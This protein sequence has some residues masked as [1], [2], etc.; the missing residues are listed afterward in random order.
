V[1]D[2]VIGRRACGYLKILGAAFQADGEYEVRVYGLKHHA[3]IV[4]L[5]C[6]RLPLR[7]G[8]GFMR[9]RDFIKLIGGG[10]AAWPLVARAQQATKTDR[11]AV[12]HPSVPVA[13]MTESGGYPYY[14][15]LFKELRRLGY[16]EGVNLVVT[17]YSAEGREE[18]FPGLC[19]EVVRTNPDIIVTATSRL[20]LSFKATTATVPIVAIMADPVPYGI[21]PNI[22]R[23]GG[24]ITGVSVDARLEIW[25]KRLQ[26]LREVVPTASKVGFLV[27]RQTWSL[28]STDAL[29]EAAQQLGISLLGPPMES[30][31]Q[32]EEY[33]RVLG[34]MAQEHVDGVII[35]DQA[36]HGTY[37]QLIVDLV[38]A[39][40]LP[41]IFPYRE[42]FEFG[43]LMAY[44]PSG[45][46][47]WRRIA[48]YVGQILNGA[49]PGDLPIYLQS[50]FELL[51]N[52]ATA[53]AL[54]LNIPPSLLARA[55]EVIE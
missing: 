20:V 31:I 52:L 13:D 19:Q 28:P 1:K 29:R 24:N 36:E 34:A 44:G 39:A 46:E 51:V 41:A 47:I 37:Q 22:A 49:H 54:G 27:S 17:R 33:R 21:V 42:Y 5:R 38:D 12:V 32:A 6:G 7:V 53:K 18:R 10:A 9:R 55:D 43:A 16:I 23:P 40:K 30:P 48:G 15:A 35:G 45:K 4:A 26:I 3:Q 11:I 50:K 25:G 8:G 14:A 2:G